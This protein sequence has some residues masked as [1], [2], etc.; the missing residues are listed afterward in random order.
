MVSV[1]RFAIFVAA[2]AVVTSSPAWAKGGTIRRSEPVP[3]EGAA[4]S[5]PQS[6]SFINFAG[7]GRGRYRDPGTHQCRGPADLGN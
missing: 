7:C 3:M 2:L 1:A 4:G 5:L 6:T